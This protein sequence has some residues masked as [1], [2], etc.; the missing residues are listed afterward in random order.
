MIIRMYSE[1]DGIMD[2]LPAMKNTKVACIL[3]MEEH[4]KKALIYSHRIFA[5]PSHLHSK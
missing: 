2:L 4:Y 3:K 5:L 1:L